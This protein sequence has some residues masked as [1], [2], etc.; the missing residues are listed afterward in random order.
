MNSSSN[1]SISWKSIIQQY[2]DALK[3]KHKTF[4]DRNIIDIPFRVD[5]ENITIKIVVGNSE[6]P[7]QTFLSA[8]SIIYFKQEYTIEILEAINSINETLPIGC[9]S[10][11]RENNS[12]HIKYGFEINEGFSIEN[13]D[14]MIDFSIFLSQHTRN[15][16]RLS[17]LIKFKPD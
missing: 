9:I 1:T 8:F 10:L 6:F 7:N 15:N 14:A 11:N 12:I 3:Y 16:E 5:N 17:N 13:L 4:S 2:L